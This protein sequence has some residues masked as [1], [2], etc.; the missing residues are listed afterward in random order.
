MNQP[1]LQLIYPELSQY[2]ISKD[3]ATARKYD[4]STAVLKSSV[5]LK[6]AAYTLCRARALI[7]F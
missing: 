4:L 3:G 7:A 2:D 6:A 5:E 1:I